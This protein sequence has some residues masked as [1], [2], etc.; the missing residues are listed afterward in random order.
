[1]KNILVPIDFSKASRNA[2]GYAVSLAKVF[3][4][5]VTLINVIPP[6]V[7]ID[8][9]ILATVMI[10][11]AEIL[12]NNKQLVQK[13][14]EALSKKYP[15]KITGL[16]QEG[17]P[18]DI[19]QEIAKEKHAD[20]IVM[21]MKGKGKSNS[22][23]GSTT[24]TVIRKLS[25]PVLV[26]PEKAGYSQI[27]NITFASDFDA[28]MEVDRYSLLQELAKKFNSQ[29][30]ILNV[31]KKDSAMNADEVIGKMKT[32]VVFSKLN[33]E[34]QAINERNVE[35]GINKFIENKPTDILAMVAHRHN[36][37]ERIF[38]KVHTKKMSYQTKVPLLVLQCK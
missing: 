31:Q 38:G 26:I 19:I 27:N 13:E 20:L 14:V 23:F 33:H 15:A 24:T 11:Q 34:F 22:V 4:A 10:T 7:I 28:E 2:S 30:H 9:S 18:A 35:E 37:L 3:D 17:F 29:V 6:A 5:S 21:G 8:D 36:L 12:E 32:N 1:M 16:V 25:F